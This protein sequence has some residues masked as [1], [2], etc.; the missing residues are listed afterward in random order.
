MKR[1]LIV[2]VVVGLGCSVFSIVVSK[3]RAA[4]EGVLQQAAWER[5]KAARAAELDQARRE[6]KPPL[7]PNSPPPEQLSPE[8]AA[9]AVSEAEKPATPM[10]K[11][12][13]A[14]AVA[15]QPL[16]NPGSQKAWQDP[17]A[18]MAL[19]LAGADPDAEEVWA[20]A[21]NNPDLPPKERQ[22][23]IEDLN[24]EGFPDPKH[25][26]AEDLPM[27]LGRIELIEEHAPEAMDEVNWRAF[28]EAYKDLLN[29][30]DR[31]VREQGI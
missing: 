30:L 26:T 7:A 2:L 24:E 18:R 16:P 9:P 20:E 31:V 13:E 27:I 28:M 17:V 21:I 23:L 1:A 10:K 12:P 19:S 4:Q 15:P 11:P 14:A 25:L 8:P 29:M 6:R 5:A 22:D 3:R